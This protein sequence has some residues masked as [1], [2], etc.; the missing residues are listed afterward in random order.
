MNEEFTN[1]KQYNIA[2]AFFKFSIETNL[3]TRINQEL[4]IKKQDSYEILEENF[5]LPKRDENSESF[6]P[7]IEKIQI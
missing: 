2:W 4:K 1:I 6:E 5:R 3:F 7:L